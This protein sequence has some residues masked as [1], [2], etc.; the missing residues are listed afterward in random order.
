MESAKVIENPP[1]TKGRVVEA[2]VEKYK[3]TAITKG[4]STKQ[5]TLDFNKR[6]MHYI[7]PKERADKA[8]IIPFD[9]ISSLSVD[10]SKAGKY[11][12]NVLTGKRPYKFKFMTL[13]SWIVFTTALRHLFDK[14]SQS[15]IFQP[16]E[17]YLD[18]ILKYEGKFASGG[19]YAPKLELVKTETPQKKLEEVKQEKSQ[20]KAVP[21]NPDVSKMS[22]KDTANINQRETGYEGT[23]TENNSQKGSTKKIQIKEKD[24]G[25]DS[26]S[27]SQNSE[28][29][30]GKQNDIVKKRKN[31]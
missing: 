1:Y 20:T 18:I 7:A 30:K 8:Q 23:K 3:Q 14:K 10:L 24:K 17:A 9:E 15:A 21:S 19:E 5:L 16:G 11:K 13:D 28:D 31:V 12:L 4:K 27:E 6:N 29:I 26:D 25:K 2:V 22:G